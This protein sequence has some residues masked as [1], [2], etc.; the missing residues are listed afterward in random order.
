MSLLYFVYIYIYGY[1]NISIYIYRYS[2][3]YHTCRVVH[4]ADG[5]QTA[6][7]YI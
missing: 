4:I 1:I 7:S 3:M 2:D 6:N 5:D